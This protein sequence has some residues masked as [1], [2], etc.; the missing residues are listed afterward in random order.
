VWVNKRMGM[1]GV[2]IIITDTLVDSGGVGE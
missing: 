1:A 2:D